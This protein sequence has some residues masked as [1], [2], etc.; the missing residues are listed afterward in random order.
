MQYVVEHLVT[1]SFEENTWYL[2]NRG[3][4]EGI[5]FDPGDNHEKISAMIQSTG[6]RPMAILN[7][8]GHIDHIGAI[9]KLQDEYD[10]PFYLHSADEFLI[11][12]YPQ[13]AAMFGLEM[14][15]MPAISGF[16]D[17]IVDENSMIQLA[18][19][20]IQVIPTPG[21]TPGGVSYLVEDVL[22]VGDTLFSGSVGRTDLPGGN[23]NTLMHS[24]TKELFELEDEVLVHSGHGPDT[25]I[26]RERES[27]PFV[28]DWLRKQNTDE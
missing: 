9:R 18:G 7:T 24:I 6:S 28:R 2:I 22:F 16:I 20:A 27:N 11:K 17:E 3:I 1:G 21:H 25:T 23:Y 5:I 15:G 8:H 10:L 12:Q 26:G 13:H 4:G 14:Q 19:T